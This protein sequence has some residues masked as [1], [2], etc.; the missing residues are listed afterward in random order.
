MEIKWRGGTFADRCPIAELH[1]RGRA[2]CSSIRQTT[3]RWSADSA[4]PVLH[5]EAGRLSDRSE[6]NMVRLGE[7][8]HCLAATS[9]LKCSNWPSLKSTF[10]QT[11]KYMHC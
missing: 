4:S 7:D 11:M 5:T 1:P 3:L 6:R 2:A 9:D 8:S 10:L